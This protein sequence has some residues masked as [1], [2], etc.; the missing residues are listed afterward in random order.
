MKN[1]LEYE[2]NKLISYVNDNNLG[3]GWKNHPNRLYNGTYVDGEPFDYVIFTRKHKYAFDAKQTE[4]SVWNICKKDKVQ[5]YNLL[6]LSKSGINCF[7]LIYFISPK[8]L[9]RI[10]ITDFF[11]ILEQRSHIKITDCKIWNYKEIFNVSHDNKQSKG[12][13]SVNKGS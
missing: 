7:F 10:S 12:T 5:A 1:F 8:K 2:I 3:F 13:N 6:K 4:Q 9:V 11:K